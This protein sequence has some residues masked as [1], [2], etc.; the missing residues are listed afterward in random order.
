MQVLPHPST[1]AFPPWKGIKSSEEQGPLLPLM[2]NKTML[3]S[4]CNWSHGSLN[5]YSSVDGLVSE[6]S[7]VYGCLILYFVCVAN[8][9][10]P[11]SPL[12]N[13]HTEDQLLR[14]IF[15]C[16]H[17]PLYLPASVNAT[18]ETIPGILQQALL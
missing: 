12:S 6:S 13:F 9:F 5:V 7:G 2:S 10:S 17:L 11:N 16:K 15:R 8:H 18:Q 4:I 14:T 1:S 3:Y